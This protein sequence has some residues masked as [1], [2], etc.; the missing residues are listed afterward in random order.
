MSDR[1]FICA[2]CSVLTFEDVATCPACGSE[3]ERLSL[4][5]EL[6]DGVSA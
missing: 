2:D 6:P 5:F 3:A 4:A 1:L